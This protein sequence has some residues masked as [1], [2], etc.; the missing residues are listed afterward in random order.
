MGLI[1][2][3]IFNI[4]IF[5]AIVPVVI[6]LTGLLA[7]YSI[8]FQIWN[9]ILHLNEKSLRKLGGSSS[10]SGCMLRGL[11]IFFLM[12][13]DAFLLVLSHLFF[14][15]LLYL[16]VIIAALIGVLAALV[17]LI[18]ITPAITFFVPF[19]LCRITILQIRGLQ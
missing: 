10:R 2:V 15:I 3:W 19:Y 12:S 18:F 6:T 11:F 7:P 8:L 9:W 16:C 1:S 4:P 5:A 13:T 17:S 14:P